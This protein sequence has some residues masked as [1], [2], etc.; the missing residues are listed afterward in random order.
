MLLRRTAQQTKPHRKVWSDGPVK[1]IVIHR[2]SYDGGTVCGCELSSSVT[3]EGTIADVT[4]PRCKNR[5]P[6]N[7]YIGYNE[8]LAN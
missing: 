6:R 8:D 1:P 7:Y 2:S 3:F 5:E 4:C